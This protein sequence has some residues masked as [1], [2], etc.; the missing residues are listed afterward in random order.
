M[1]VSLW[2]PQKESLQNIIDFVENE[3]VEARNIKSTK[4]RNKTISALNSIKL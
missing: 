2:V 1:K 3:I 4:N